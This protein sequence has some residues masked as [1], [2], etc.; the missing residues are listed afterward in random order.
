[1]KGGGRA[2][3]AIRPAW[4]DTAGPGAHAGGIPRLGPQAE[5]SS[6]WINRD[7]EVQPPTERE[8]LVVDALADKRLYEQELAR[9]REENAFLQDQV[10]RVTSELK[11][12]QLRFPEAAEAAGVT[13]SAGASRGGLADGGGGG[14]GGGGA[15]GG[16]GLGR[17]AAD[18]LPP[19]VTSSEVMSPLLTAYDAR[20]QDLEGQIA[21]QRDGMEEL[22]ARTHQLV[23]ENDQLR[24]EHTRELDEL[25]EQ[26]GASGGL[27]AVG[28]REMVGE[29]N[30]RINILMAENTVMADQARTY[31]S[32][33]A[34]E[35]DAVHEE[36]EDREVQMAALA[37]AL[38]EA[39]VGLRT[40]EER[41]PQLEREKAHAEGELMKAV[42]AMS[43]REAAVSEMGEK[44]RVSKEEA[45]RLSVKVAEME[46]DR[47]AM[48]RQTEND[49][50]VTAERVRAAGQRITELQG[51][52]A[53]R[54]Q[55]ADVNG[56]RARKL[57]RDLEST[58]RDAEGM[59]Q[60]MSGMERQIADLT[61]REESTAS[62]AKESKQKVEDALLARD[63][64]RALEIQ[65]RRELARV[66]EARKADAA[67][68]VREMEEAALTLRNK[69]Q[70]QVASRDREI[71]ASLAEPNP[72]SPTPA[73]AARLRGEAERAGR[74]RAGMEEVY[75]SLKRGVEAETQSLKA[76]FDEL[77]ARVLEAD[78]KRDQHDAAAKELGQVAID[79]ERE[80]A[81]KEAMFRGK[82]AHLE[83]TLKA[84]E[85]EL[86]SIRTS[87]RAATDHAESRQ[88]E[89]KRLA[90][91]LEETREEYTR[92]LEEETLVRKAEA[93][94]AKAHAAVLE[95][96]LRDAERRAGEVEAS[97]KK[98]LRAVQERE[99]SV[100]LSTERRLREEGELAQR[101]SSRNTDLQ[102]RLAQLAAE[103]GEAE[104]AA[105][106]GAED[107]ARLEKQLVDARRKLSE[108]TTQLSETIGQ[109]ETRARDEG[110]LRSELKRLQITV[111]RRDR[112]A[113]SA[114]GAGAASGP[115]SARLLSQQSRM[116]PLALA[117]HGVG[118]VGGA[119]AG[120]GGG[121]G[122]DL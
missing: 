24:Q 107:K 83:D 49:A 57:Q 94:D 64:A 95:R 6:A 81:A 9:I 122:G 87:Q 27:G 23:E 18:D 48:E 62:I 39:G 31:T 19:W 108:L 7:G 25:V 110:R 117:D 58:R 85:R 96:S 35:L 113:S 74:D 17:D 111:Q 91:L 30:E 28:A 60:V 90:S 120:G 14:G 42:N 5:R 29:L 78:A 54:G 71:Q 59:L 55:E 38:G 82:E 47:A 88:R 99:R 101:L 26:A 76:K 40:L 41:V 63:Q 36:F 22:A 116:R 34:K 13:A 93:D 84:R 100:G 33:M 20:I 67:G 119:G 98:Q 56:D 51:L 8:A 97:F 16:L 68:H 72:L 114:R 32:A 102:G 1:M 77:Q 52:L 50:D 11:R 44:L 75:L 46:A 79:A 70:A 106:R 80:F 15:D 45:R 4:A 118:D 103:R 37:K 65:S 21:A 73:Q 92:K 2:A 109:A 89:A 12:Y 115:H 43:E 112:E 69:F 61:S 66:L 3:A 105:V 121:A 10:R 104:A 53:A 86:E